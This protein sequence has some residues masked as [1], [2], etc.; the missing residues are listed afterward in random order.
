MLGTEEFHHVFPYERFSVSSARCATCPIRF[1]CGWGARVTAARFHPSSSRGPRDR[2]P[3]SISSGLYLRSACFTGARQL[4]NR[5]ERLHILFNFFFF[6]NWKCLRV[7]KGCSCALI[8]G[9]LLCEYG[10]KNTWNACPFRAKLKEA[11]FSGRE[12]ELRYSP[13]C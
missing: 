10:C 11:F 5:H 7:L 3:E 9:C 6:F 8:K 1:G 2:I 4:T 12:I 13:V